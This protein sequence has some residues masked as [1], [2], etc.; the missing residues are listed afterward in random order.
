M[1]LRRPTNVGRFDSFI[2]ETF[3]KHR[4]SK[5]VVFVC[6]NQGMSC[7][8]VQLLSSLALLFAGCHGYGYDL[9]VR[10]R[11][12]CP[13]GRVPWGPDGDEVSCPGWKRREGRCRLAYV[14]LCEADGTLDPDDLPL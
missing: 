9:S 3:Y 5:G 1:R 11:V 2:Y 10:G 7:L 14:K 12:L 6:Y 13:D 8:L 4:L